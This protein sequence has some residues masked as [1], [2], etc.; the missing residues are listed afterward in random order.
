MKIAIVQ[1]A[2]FPVPA[3]MGGA[4]EKVW[5][6]LGQEFA[7]LGHDVIHIGC[8]HPDLPEKEI[9]AGVKYIRVTGYETPASLTRLKFLDLLYSIRA[10]KEIPENI[11]IIVTNT[12][13]SPILL[14]GRYSK[15]L[16]VNIERNPKV[17][18]KLY[19]HAGMIR[20]G[21]PFIVESIKKKLPFR[22]HDI[23]S[24]VAN[25]I[26]FDVKPT[27]V[28]KGNCILFVGRIHPEKGVGIL[29]KA[30]ELINTDW[31]LF[32][33]GPHSYEAGGGGEEYFK[34][35]LILAKSSRN[36]EFVGPIY[37]EVRLVH[38]YAQASIF[39]YPAQ[40]DSGDAA[41]VAPREAMAYG[42]VPVVSQLDCFND[43][44]VNGSNGI[45][46]NHRAEN[47][48]YELS[49]AL[50]MLIKNDEERKRLSNQAM[51]ITIKYAPATIARK[52]VKDFERM[53]VSEQNHY[54]N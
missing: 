52:F 11:D 4:V 8:S 53:V 35:L 13:W 27:Y 40:E 28:K 43:I 14:R 50:N 12:F 17:Q 31:K 33:V 7:A 10:V 51:Q 41:P 42:C 29:I 15:K 44:I 16:Y 47:Q 19:N 34:E 32:I 1:G 9:I 24:Y 22:L 38:Y 45:C 23:V 48:I 6:R 5:Y 30:F 37:E 21:S 36:I 18:I 26:P 2:F 54:V 46:Y 49:R 25:P 20:G 39:C 3:I